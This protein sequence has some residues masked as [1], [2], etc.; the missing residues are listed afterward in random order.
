MTQLFGLT[1][2]SFIGIA[3]AFMVM[4]MAGGLESRAISDLRIDP[5]TSAASSEAATESIGELAPL[6][7]YSTR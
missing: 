6:A 1:V 5:S 4:T 7:P 2:L 3:I